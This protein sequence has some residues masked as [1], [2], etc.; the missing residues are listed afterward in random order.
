[1]NPFV[2]DERGKPRVIVDARALAAIE[3]EVLAA[4]LSSGCE[5]GGLLVGPPGTRVVFEFIPS[6][7]EAERSPTG[8]RTD[9]A[10]LQ[11]RLDAA[12][13]RHGGDVLG[14]LHSHPA[15]FRQPSSQDLGEARRMLFDPGYKALDERVLMPIATVEQGRD[16]PRVVIDWFEVDLSGRLGWLELQVV[17]HWE[18]VEQLEQAI[19]AEGFDIEMAHLAADGLALLATRDGR[20]YCWVLP[21]VWP[22]VPARL[23]RLEGRVPVEELE[24]PT[25]GLVPR[26]TGERE[27]AEGAEGPVWQRSG[28]TAPGDGV[29]AELARRTGRAPTARVVATDRVWSK[30]TEGPEGQLRGR[31][32]DHR[33]GS[34]TYVVD[35]AGATLPLRYERAA[36]QVVVLDRSRALPVEPLVVEFD[37]DF[38]SRRAGLVDPMLSACRV[39]VVGC[40]SVGAAVALDL[41]RAG[42]GALTLVDPDTVSVANLSRAPFTLADLG[43][44]KVDAVD[45]RVRLINPGV[46]VERH[47]ERLEAL[48]IGR[49]AAR[50]DLV[51][52]AVDRPDAVRAA[53][54]AFH[55]A[56]PAVY[57]GVYARGVGGEVL[58]TRPERDGVPASPS[59]RSVLQEIRFSASPPPAAEAWDYSDSG[60][61]KAE[62]ALVAQIGHVVSVA[63]LIALALLSEGIDP[64]SMMAGLLRPGWSG[65][66][67]SNGPDWIFDTPFQGVWAEFE[68]EDEDEVTAEAPDDRSGDGHGLGGRCAVTPEGESPELPG[69]A[70]AL[71]AEDEGGGDDASG[72]ESSVD[73]EEAESDRVDEDDEP[74][75]AGE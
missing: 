28:D 46:D 42:V 4:G 71:C 56:V 44:F 58:F 25:D 47:A 51:V 48:D 14:Y 31:R 27:A 26:S 34:V 8:Y 10:H 43:R 9:P 69:T 57:P 49:L 54:E 70:L 53:D 63:S 36:G 55:R 65:V 22:E 62:P 1:M 18:A 16:G 12:H 39:A 5:T 38:A 41:V 40:G 72:A 59:L 33:D 3:A 52:V 61:L 35:P 74:C 45:D 67:V 13:R 73:L 60:R 7:R 64:D 21:P 75:D 2:E 20:G 30:V 32:I 24:V 50:C 6:G 11:A 19:A 37:A 68:D 66:F 29:V 15:G 17:P 23:F